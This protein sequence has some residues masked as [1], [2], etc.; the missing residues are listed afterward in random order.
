MVMGGVVVGAQQCVERLGGVVGG[1]AFEDV[2]VVCSSGGGVLVVE[3]SAEPLVEVG[4][5]GVAATGHRDVGKGP[6]RGDTHE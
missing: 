1:A 2:D 4:V 3:F 5:V 6:C